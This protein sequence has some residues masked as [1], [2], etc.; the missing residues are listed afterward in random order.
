[1]NEKHTIPASNYPVTI[2]AAEFLQGGLVAQYPIFA[3]DAVQRIGRL[4]QLD[5]AFLNQPFND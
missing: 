3:R 5:E 1:M 2:H 4:V